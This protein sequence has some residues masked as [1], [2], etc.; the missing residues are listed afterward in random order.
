MSELFIVVGLKAKVGKEDELSERAGTLR[1]R[2]GVVVHRD[3]YQASRAWLPHP[4]L[5][6]E[7]CWQRRKDGV[8]AYVEARRL[9]QFGTT[10]VPGGATWSIGA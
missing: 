10:Q 3:A 8:R 1:I 9:T 5:S 4:A 6:H 2:G 7:W